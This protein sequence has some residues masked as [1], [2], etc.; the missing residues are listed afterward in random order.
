MRLWIVFTIWKCIS[1]KW[2][3]SDGATFLTVLKNQIIY[4]YSLPSY[5]VSFY[6]VYVLNKCVKFLKCGILSGD[7]SQLLMVLWMFLGMCALLYCKGPSSRYC[8]QNNS[9]LFD[10][11]M[12]NKY[13]LNI[14]CFQNHPYPC[15]SLKRKRGWE[16][17]VVYKAT[18]IGL[19][20]KT[21]LKNKKGIK[22]APILIIFSFI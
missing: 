16:T 9:Q 11:R 3:Y 14:A 18:K 19:G 7:V 17:Q 12:A 15:I 8:G 21:S 6:A 2:H 4:Y 22:K 5:I 1:C 20:S 13:L 10:R